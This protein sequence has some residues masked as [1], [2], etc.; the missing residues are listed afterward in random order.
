LGPVSYAG[1]LIILVPFGTSK[2]KP[3]AFH[4]TQHFAWIDQISFLGA[5]DPQICEVPVWRLFPRC[6]NDRVARRVTRNDVLP[7][8]REDI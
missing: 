3:I 6:G 4:E 5:T 7:K 8:F 2:E 1:V